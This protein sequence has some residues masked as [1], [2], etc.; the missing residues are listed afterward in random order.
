VASV[1]SVHLQHT[2]I[3]SNISA[4]TVSWSKKLSM[5]LPI[6]SAKLWAKIPTLT[7]ILDPRRWM[8]SV[9]NLVGEPAQRLCPAA[10]R[11]RMLADHE[12]VHA[13]LGITSYLR[14]HFCRVAG[15][16]G[17]PGP[18]DPA[19]RWSG[20]IIVTA[21]HCTSATRRPAVKHCVANWPRIRP[22]E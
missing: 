3:I 7:R 20:T 21:P 6:V 14:A 4:L 15:H 12:L 11:D 19:G 8:L 5:T 13:S 16:H 9:C 18:P 1:S 17:L 2:T 10:G 22:A